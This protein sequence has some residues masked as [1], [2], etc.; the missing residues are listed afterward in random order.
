MKIEV[1][2]HTHTLA[3]GHA[4]STLIE[5]AAAAQQ[6]GLK[7]FCTTDHTATMPGAPHFWFFMN[8]QILPRFLS[9]VGVLRG[10]EVNILNANG[11]IDLPAQ[12]DDRLDW[13]IA[14]L[15][16]PC[17]PPSSKNDHTQGL[18]NVIKSGRVDALAHLGNP[19]FDFDFKKV[20]ECA[21]ENNVAV[22]INNSSLTGMSRVGSIDRCRE[23]AL[24]AK[25]LEVFITT[26]SD[27]HFCLQIGK[28]DLASK[29]LDEIE[30]PE[31]QVITHS[32]AQFLA[33]LAL[34]NRK[35]IAAF[36]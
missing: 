30:M 6:Q 3:S 9:G 35:P 17:F 1:D 5:N 31:R 29:L 12:V 14:S 20:I 19:N 27:A 18:L 16:E 4:Y 8:Q 11:D 33:F 21:K 22:E 24:I 23:I 7:L 26:G 28:F 10:A 25:Q 2:T 15:H 32:T 13:V 34:R 36:S